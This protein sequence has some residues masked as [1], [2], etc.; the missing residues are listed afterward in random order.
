MAGFALPLRLR[1]H[2]A[3]VLSGLEQHFPPDNASLNFISLSDD[4]Y[5]YA[6]YPNLIVNLGQSRRKIIEDISQAPQNIIEKFTDDADWRE[7]LARLYQACPIFEGKI[8]QQIRNAMLTSPD[9]KPLVGHLADNFWCA[10]GFELGF[11]QLEFLNLGLAPNIAAMINDKQAISAGKLD[12]EAINPNRFGAID[13]NRLTD[14]VIHNPLWREQILTDEKDAVDSLLEY[15]PHLKVFHD[16]GAM[17][18]RK[19]QMAHPIYFSQA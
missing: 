5:F 11:S 14:D 2:R 8:T 16:D 1:E 9:N 18:A 12:D 17:L 13:E 3:F 10:C 19:G 6:D 4:F 15:Y 7:D